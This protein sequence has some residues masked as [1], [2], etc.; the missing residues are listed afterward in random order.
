[1]T[2]VPAK[3]QAAL[4]LVALLRSVL[5]LVSRMGCALGLALTH[6]DCNQCFWERRGVDPF[7][8]AP[9]LEVQPCIPVRKSMS[10]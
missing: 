10:V 6:Q 9:V 4:V 8:L 1:M 5:G 2:F 3:H 7:C